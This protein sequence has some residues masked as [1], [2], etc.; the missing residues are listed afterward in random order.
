LFYAAV[1]EGLI[2]QTSVLVDMMDT[3][4]EVKIKARDVLFGDKE[5]LNYFKQDNKH[6]LTKQHVS[7]INNV[8]SGVLADFRY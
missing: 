8:H 1:F 6:I 5:I 2:P 4:M 7:F 3:S